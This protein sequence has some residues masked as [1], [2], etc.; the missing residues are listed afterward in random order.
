M[1]RRDGQLGR[2]L[3]ERVLGRGQAELALE[4]RG[5]GG[6][7]VGIREAQALGRVEKLLGFLH[8]ARQV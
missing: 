1:G 5:L 7:F 8:K 3:V 6:V 2:D 4:Q